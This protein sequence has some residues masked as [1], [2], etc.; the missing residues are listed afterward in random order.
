M[1]RNQ[2]TEITIVSTLYEHIQSIYWQRFAP[3]NFPDSEKNINMKR[4][5]NI[6]S[7][8]TIEIENDYLFRKCIRFLTSLITFHA[9]LNIE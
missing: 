1:H 8:I 7:Y 6:Y 3:W 9:I 4:I 2:D 5:L